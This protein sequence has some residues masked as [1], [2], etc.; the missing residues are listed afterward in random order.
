MVILGRGAVEITIFALND[1][2]ITFAKFV[3]HQFICILIPRNDHCCIIVVG[4]PEIKEVKALINLY[5]LLTHFPFPK[6]T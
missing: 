1:S 5:L 4:E 3:K 6:V 2:T